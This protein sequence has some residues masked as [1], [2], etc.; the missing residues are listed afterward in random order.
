VGH[1]HVPLAFYL[2]PGDRVTCERLWLGRLERLELRE[3]R[4]IL[5][6]G[7]LGQPRDRDP[8]SPYFI[9][10]TE[11]MTL[12]IRRVPYPVEVTQR[13]MEEAGLPGNLI[14]RLAFGW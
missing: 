1:T 5:N 12:E 14:L 8:S 7:G 3:G 10:D 13:R 11:A 6:P 2:P 9:L 4:W